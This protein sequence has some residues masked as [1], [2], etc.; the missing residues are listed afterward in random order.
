MA[1]PKMPERELTKV[2][3]AAIEERK[4]NPDHPAWSMSLA[5]VVKKFQNALPGVVGLNGAVMRAVIAGDVLIVKYDSGA[6]RPIF[7][8]ERYLFN[9]HAV[10]AQRV[11]RLRKAKEKIEK[12]NLAG[13]MPL[14]WEKCGSGEFSTEEAVSHLTAE[15]L[16]KETAFLAVEEVD[17]FSHEA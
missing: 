12:K 6:V 11:L 17:L 3:A 2:T 4:S 10:Y 14:L 1:W 8:S 7:K 15:G 9:Q 16:D 13:L 5:S